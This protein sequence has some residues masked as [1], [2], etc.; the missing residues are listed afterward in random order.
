MDLDKVDLKSKLVPVRGCDQMDP[1]SSQ[2]AVAE[3][4]KA[5]LAGS[6]TDHVF[7]RALE[8]VHRALGVE[9][10]WILETTGSGTHAT[11]AKTIGWHTRFPV[12]SIAPLDPTTQPGYPLA[13]DEPI[14]VAYWDDDSPIVRVTAIAAAGVRAGMSVIIPVGNTAYGVLGVHTCETRRFTTDEADF[15]RSIANVLGSTVVN[16]RARQEIAVQSET[17]ER[18]LR[19]QAA[20]AECAQTLL[21]N[22]G[23]DRLDRAVRALLTATQATYVP[24]S[25]THLTLPTICSV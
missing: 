8:L 11:V 13:S 24:V 20:L 25:Y 14:S 4:G 7:E 17:Q 6:S 18:R 19:Y 12:G 3:L 9:F 10:G 15:L 23:E 1:I 5:A 2:A 21:G 22:T 16:H